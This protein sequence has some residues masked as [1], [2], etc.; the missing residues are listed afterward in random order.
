MVCKQMETQGLVR[1]TFFL[2]VFYEAA[3]VHLVGD[4]NG[5]CESA[6]PMSR[7]S[8]GW[9]VTLSLP[10]GKAYQYRYLVDD[11]TWLNDWHADHYLPNELGGDNS[12]I[13]T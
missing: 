12:V 10:P 1:V 4:F 7:T 13:L 8:L 9:Q 2:P 6:T 3:C 11:G 5:W